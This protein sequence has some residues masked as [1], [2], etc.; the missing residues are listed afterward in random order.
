MFSDG[1]PAGAIGGG[2][3]SAL[4]IIVVVLVVVVIFMVVRRKRYA[5][6]LQCLTEIS[7]G[8]ILDIKP[9]REYYLLS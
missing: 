5:L 1:T 2:L 6:G 7:V 3:G 8:G 4:V 9:L